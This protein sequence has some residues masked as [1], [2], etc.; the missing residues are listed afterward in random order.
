LALG[1][2]FFNGLFALMILSILFPWFQRSIAPLSDSIAVEIGNRE[3]FSFGSIRLWGA[4]SFAIGTFV[5]GFVY[6]SAGYGYSFLFFFILN[7]L[8][9]AS[10][11][12]LPKTNAS[13]RKLSVFGQ[14]KQVFWNKTFMAFIGICFLVAMSTAINFSFMPIYLK[15]IGFNKIWIGVAY[16]VTALV[17]VPMFWLS[18]RL[19]EKVGRMSILCLAAFCYGLKYLSLLFIHHESLIIAVQLL[20]GI[21]FAL[22]ASATVEVVST[23]AEKET[24]A[25]YQAVFAAI[26]SGLGGIIGSAIGGIV[27]DHWGMPALYVILSLC[28]FAA[29][30]LFVL[31][32]LRTPEAGRTVV[33]D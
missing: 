8:V 28:C 3:G 18:S 23:F 9:L 15:E 2:Y 22:F 29:A 32:K 6:E 11:F 33:T 4:L 20:E 25:T 16:S 1:F 17:E 5:T 21:S 19:N 30:A 27:I 24:K 12:L 14:A 26:T 10:L 13:A 7:G 31:F